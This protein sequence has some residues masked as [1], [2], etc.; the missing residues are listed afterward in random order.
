MAFILLVIE[1]LTASLRDAPSRDTQTLFLSVPHKGTRRQIQTSDVC[2]DPFT[3]GIE[4]MTR[5]LI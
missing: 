5:R 1:I 2:V 3:H 4:T